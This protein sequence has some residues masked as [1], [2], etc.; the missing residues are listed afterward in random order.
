V[1]VTLQGR[2]PQKDF[3]RIFQ[4]LPAGPDRLDTGLTICCKLL[5]V[6]VSGPDIGFRMKVKMHSEKPTSKMMKAEHPA[7]RFAPQAQTPAVI[8]SEA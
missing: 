8:L 7:H 4:Q 3:R 6:G 1:T 5:T 2:D